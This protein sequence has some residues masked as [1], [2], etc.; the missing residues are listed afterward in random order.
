MNVSRLIQR[1][2]TENPEKTANFEDRRIS[3]LELDSLIDRAAFGFIELGLGRGDVLSLFLPRL[4]E[5]IIAYLGAVR[6]G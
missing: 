2:V 5:L 3:Y 4:P 6:V 1:H